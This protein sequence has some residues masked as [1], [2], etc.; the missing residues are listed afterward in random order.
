MFL[1][2]LHLS[3]QLVSGLNIAVTEGTVQM[4]GRLGIPDGI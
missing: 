2:P 3:D 4:E 1:L